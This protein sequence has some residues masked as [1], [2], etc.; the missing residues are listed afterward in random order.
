M[1]IKNKLTVTRVGSITGG[2]RGWGN[3]RNK[4][5]ELMGMD[6]GGGIDCGM[7]GRGEQRGE[8]VGE[9]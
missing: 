3:S 8:K 4:D 1:E 6:N 7:W 2:R 9:L 5:K